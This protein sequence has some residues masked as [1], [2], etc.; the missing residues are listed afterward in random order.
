MSDHFEDSFTSESAR[1]LN[2]TKLK[3]ASKNLASLGRLAF[4]HFE[5]CF[6]SEKLNQL[7]FLFFFLLRLQ[8]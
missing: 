3:K 8:A 2:K 4:C 7:A 5:N 1:I 6:T